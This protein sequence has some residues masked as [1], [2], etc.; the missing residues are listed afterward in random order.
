MNTLFEVLI[1]KHR[2]VISFPHEGY[3]MDTIRFEE[4]EKANTEF[5]NIF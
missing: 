3:W 5:Y 4:Y 1:E 2:K